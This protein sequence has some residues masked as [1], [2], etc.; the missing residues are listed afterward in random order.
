MIYFASKTLDSAQVNYTT[1]EKEF[2]AVIFALDKFRSYLTGYKVIVHSDHAA[3]RNL[4]AKAESKPR[5]TRWILMLQDFHCEIVDK[6]GKENLI[7]DHL[8]RLPFSTMQD[9]TH[10][11]RDVLPDE[12]IMSVEGEPW[13]A[14]IV[15]YLANNTFLPN[16]S[17]SER[18]AFEKLCRP[19]IWD[20]PSLSD[21]VE[22]MCCGDAFRKPDRKAS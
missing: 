22:T 12:H 13:Y 2:L 9:D 19:Y 8:S 14:D 7:V 1:T 11:I 18:S 21:E 5:L 15:N 6:S 16:M 3:L 17:P 4:L 20:D 10:P